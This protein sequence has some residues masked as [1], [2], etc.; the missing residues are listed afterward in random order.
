MY[1]KTMVSSLQHNTVD[2]ELTIIINIILSNTKMLEI[3]TLS[4]FLEVL[5]NPIGNLILVVLRTR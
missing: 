3:S 4:R 1:I 5:I 2:S